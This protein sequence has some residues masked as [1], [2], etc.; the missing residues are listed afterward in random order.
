MVITRDVDGGVEIVTLR[1]AVEMLNGLAVVDNSIPGTVR[2]WYESVTDKGV[3]DKL[4]CNLDPDCA[5]DCCESL[6]TAVALGFSWTDSS[7]GTTFWADYQD[8]VSHES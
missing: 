1:E 3:R 5:D 2:W 6:A 8:Y 7:E 4:L